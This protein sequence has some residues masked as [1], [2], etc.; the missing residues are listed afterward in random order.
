MPAVKGI[1]I[2]EDIETHPQ[3]ISFCIGDGEVRVVVYPLNE[4]EVN[5]ARSF[6]V[7][8]QVRDHARSSLR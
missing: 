6:R 4:V 7:L 2:F 8:G 3:L 5:E 1:K